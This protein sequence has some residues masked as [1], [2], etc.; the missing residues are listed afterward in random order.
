MLHLRDGRNNDVVFLG[1][2]N[3]VRKAG[4]IDGQINLAHGSLF[5]LLF[6]NIRI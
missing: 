4:L 3:V 5:L 1:L 2:L 6:V